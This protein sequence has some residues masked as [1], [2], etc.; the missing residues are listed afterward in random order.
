MHL[1]P[2]LR[3]RQDAIGRNVNEPAF[4]GLNFFESIPVLR[5]HLLYVLLLTQKGFFEPGANILLEVLV[6][7]ELTVGFC[8]AVFNEISG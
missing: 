6:E 8:N 5:V 3:L 4:L 7:H 1:L 2:N